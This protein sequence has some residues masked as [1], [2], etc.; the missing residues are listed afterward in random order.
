MLLLFP[1]IAKPSEP[2]A[3]IARL[4]GMLQSYGVRHYLLDANIEGLLYIL[5]K[6]LEKDILLD[7][8]TKG[9]FHNLKKNIASMQSWFA[10]QNQ[11]RYI[12]TIKD[13]TRTLKFL[14]P[15]GT[16]IGLADYSQEIFSPTKSSDLNAAAQEPEKNPFYPYF[17]QRLRGYIEK[18]RISIVGIS[19]NYLSQA[20]CAFAIAGFLKKEFPCIKIIM[21]G[22]LVSSW[23]KTLQSNRIFDWLIDSFISGPGEKPLMDIL[24]ITG[25][26][27]FFT[28]D[29]SAFPL[30]EYFSPGFTLPYS[31]SSG[32][33]WK[34]CAFCPEKAEGNAYCPIP[35]T[36]ALKEIQEL[37]AK[38]K[39]SLLHF[40]D[41]ALSPSLMTAFSEEIP[42][43]PWYG[44][45]RITK[46][47]GDFDF[48]KHLKKT[49]CIMLKLG[50]ESGDQRVLDNLG[51]G[52]DLKMVSLALQ[53]LSQAGIATYIYLL[54]GTPAETK[55]S[56]CQTKEFTIQHSQ[57]ID[58]L[59]LAIFN[60]PGDSQDFL[61]LE[62]K[63]FSAGDLSLYTDF[64]HPDGWDRKSIRF[65]LDR[66]FKRHPAIAR[67]IQN[68]PPIFTSNHAAF[69]KFQAVK[70]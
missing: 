40:L 12:K 23:I 18:E 50:I 19:L 69:M 68:D 30:S 35:N 64:I 17:S 62:R 54:F 22:G 33:Y 49:G 11:D 24:G 53:N 41:N 60:M 16:Q 58:F 66:D 5:G 63:P 14:S 26:K 61:S 39:P 37:T 6:P 25:K 21:G 55:E 28:P 36:Q 48:C 4:S 67:I 13:I 10:Y 27:A 7:S 8:W 57:Y 46:D 42:G 20:I 32:C 38:Q 34:K 2:P 45:A 65:F 15:Q 9:A 31:A 43:I 44:F 70:L 29:Y 47:L 59:N 52:I 51:K 56:A 3:G 1:P